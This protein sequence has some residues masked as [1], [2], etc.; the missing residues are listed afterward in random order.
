MADFECGK[1]RL[2]HCGCLSCYTGL[3][4]DE[5]KCPSH[6]PSYSLHQYTEY[7]KSLAELHALLVARKYRTMQNIKQLEESLVLENK[8]LEDIDFAIN[9]VSQAMTSVTNST[10]KIKP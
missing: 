2:K 10:A 5:W 6:V 9:D 7:F 3:Y 8:S 4:L 1:Y